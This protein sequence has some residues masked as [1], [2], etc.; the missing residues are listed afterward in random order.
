MRK[1]VVRIKI[2]DG[3]KDCFIQ[4]HSLNEESEVRKCAQEIDW[5]LALSD[6]GLVSSLITSYFFSLPYIDQDLHPVW[7][8]GKWER[9][10]ILD[11]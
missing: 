9:S 2:E 7:C 5:W 4:G 3:M 10:G 1:N 6:G 8:E 11:F